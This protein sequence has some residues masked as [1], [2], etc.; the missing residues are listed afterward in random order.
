MLGLGM[1]EGEMRANG[2]MNVRSGRG[3]G[4]KNGTEE[5]EGRRWSDSEI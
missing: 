2:L 1:N 3:D 4:N 5:K